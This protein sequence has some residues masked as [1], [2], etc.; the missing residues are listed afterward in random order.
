MIGD[1]Q[2]SEWL[3]RYRFDQFAATLITRIRAREPSRK[4]Q[5]GR[6]NVTGRYPSR[7]MGRTIQFESHKVEL[8]FIREYEFDD[9]VLEYYDQPEPI[10]ISYRT[11]NG[12]KTVALTT[13]DFFVIRKDGTASWEEC[14]PEQEL[15]RQAQKTERF[16][17]NEAGK[18]QCLPGEEFAA[19]YGLCFRVRSSGEINWVWQRNMEYLSDYLQTP[20]HPVAASAESFIKAL[21]SCKQGILLSELV[22][23][24]KSY[25][26]DDIFQLIARDE[27]Y[28]DLRV[29]ALSEQDRTPVYT[30]KDQATVCLPPISVLVAQAV[31][32]EPG[33][34]LIWDGK[35]FEI[36][37]AGGENVWLMSAQGTPTS[38]NNTEFEKLVRIGAIKKVDESDRHNE[39]FKL[40]CSKG[41]AALADAN[42][43]NK[44]ILPYLSGDTTT[45]PSST[46]YGWLKRYREAEMLYGHGYLGLIDRKSE[47]GNRLPKLPA[48]SYKL[49]KVCIE[50]QF[51][52]AT[53]AS[54][55]SVY[56]HYLNACE[57]AN[58]I[59]ASFKTFM[60]RLRRLDAK[61]TEQSR[62]GFRAAYQLDE[63]YWELKP[64]IPRHGDRPFEIVHIDHTELDIELVDSVTGGNLGRPWLTLMMD[65][66]SRHILA[67]VL[68]Y[69]PPSYRSC[70]M[71][72][73]ECVRIHNRLPQTLVVDGGADFN[74]VYFEQLIA[75][76]CI[77][78]KNRPG[79]QPRF[80]SVLERLFGVTNEQF[81][82]LLRGNTQITK[83]VRQVTKAVN[84]ANLAVWTLPKLKERIGLYFFKVYE[85][86]DHP[87]LGESSRKAF[88]R[89]LAHHGVRPMKIVRYD[90]NFILSTLPSTSKGHAKV[91]Q[92]RGIK[93]N[94]FYYWHAT[95]RLT[96][97]LEVAV[98]Y[99][100]YDIGTA[101]A[102]VKGQWVRCVSPFYAMLQGRSEKEITVITQE[103]MK[104]R[105][106]HNGKIDINAQM[107][108]AFIAE[109]QGT[110]LELKE[111]RQA[112][113]MRVGENTNNIHTEGENSYPLLQ[114][115]AD[116]FELYDELPI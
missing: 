108:A 84:P 31:T 104:R 28:V 10:K 11:C 91:I 32:T 40:L 14:K 61:D 63:F 46:I 95:M 102:F 115:K 15:E 88:E 37:N 85:N 1:F 76:Y 35:L 18:W 67:Y 7:K 116:D 53:E 49:M 75:F 19:Q 114:N 99:D 68:S 30:S 44:I 26:P 66:N 92:S 41:P 13:P 22:E 65:A 23:K 9:N 59:A 113:E 73:R 77:T 2:F 105:S 8:A 90:D 34:K 110:E 64:T 107:V 6:S 98:R 43:K 21:I 36:L 56:G 54:P 3:A 5:G 45:K 72:I 33:S 52:N 97:G 94:N 16:K 4:V 55:I 39:I 47:R 62:K 60:A 79:A 106:N 70:M 25:T 86:L 42:R 29:H 96:T 81:V 24:A 48:Q 38:L 71:V 103:I 93:I 17:L 89:G 100:P 50:E 51:L 27:L 82:H 20:D 74:S 78:K 101:Y 109:T 112:A 111:M 12:R 83:N 57:N 69:E 80:G 58:V 87:S